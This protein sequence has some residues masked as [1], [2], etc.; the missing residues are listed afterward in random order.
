[1]PTGRDRAGLQEE[2]TRREVDDM[3][4]FFCL[5][6]SIRIKLNQSFKVSETKVELAQNYVESVGAICVIM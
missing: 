2:K 4:A 3:D 6:D 1:M 5:S